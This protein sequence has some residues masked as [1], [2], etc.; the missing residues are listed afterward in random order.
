MDTK[1]MPKTLDESWRIM[2]GQLWERPSPE[3]PTWLSTVRHGL[4]VC[5]VAVEGFVDDLCLLRASALTFASLMGLVPI[6]ALACAV[7]RGLGWY[8]GRLEELILSKATILSPDAIR[9]IVSY[10]DNT[11]FAGLGVAG[12]AVLFVTAV[13]VLTNVEGSLNAIWGNSTRRPLVRR[14]MDYCGVLV[15]APVLLAVATSLTAAVQSSMVVRWFSD[16][17]SLG[18]TVERL[19]GFAA[20]GSV[21]LLFG[22]IYAFIPN[23]SVRL[24]PAVIGGVIAGTTWQLTQWGYIRFQIGMANYNAIY[25]ALAQLPLLMAWV[26]V[27]WVIV[28][29]GAEIVYAVQTV[30]DYGRERRLAGANGHAL[31]EY[32]GLR[33][34]TELGRVSLGKRSAPNPVELAEAL[35]LP[36]GMVRDVLLVFARSGI[37]HATTETG[38]QWYLSRAPGSVP[39]AQVLEVLDGTL[40]ATYAR[41]ADDAPVTQ[42]LNRMCDDRR[43]ALE[44]VTLEKLSS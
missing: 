28:L 19:L 39:V 44:S 37:A 2:V 23:T 35:D 22:F 11:N 13:S 42:I 1:P 18:G 17:W 12:G 3:E 30:Q 4:R 14:T 43:S 36:V 24:V 41:S 38:G 21:W 32:A 34:A 16:A 20:Q 8:G 7:L 25:G 40:P 27:S 31:L 15:I 29:F 10:I 6:M 26:Y 9:T 33:I 5:Y